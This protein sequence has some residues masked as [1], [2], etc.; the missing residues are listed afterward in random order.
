MKTLRKLIDEASCLGAKDEAVT[1]YMLKAVIAL[2][3]TLDL[4]DKCE[5]ALRS[6]HV[7]GAATWR[8]GEPISSDTLAREALAAIEAFKKE[9]GE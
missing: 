4:I 1:A 5:A 8:E 9:Y 3:A 6:R 2:P 7:S